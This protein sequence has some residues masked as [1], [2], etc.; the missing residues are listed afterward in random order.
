MKR[1][2]VGVLMVHGIQGGPKQFDF[3]KAALP[4]SY[5]VNCPTLPGHGKDIKE[6]R[7]S[8]NAQWLAAV[9]EAAEQMRPQC[10]R[11]FYV[12]HSMGCL[13]GILVSQQ[14]PS[15]FDGLLLRCCPYKTHPSAELFRQRLLLFQKH[16]SDQLIE[17][18]QQA[19]SVSAR[20][21]LDFLSC[22]HPYSQLTQLIALANRAPLPPVPVR[23]LFSEKDEIVSPSSAAIAAAKGATDIHMLSGCGHQ[24]FTQEARQTVIRQLFALIEEQ[25]NE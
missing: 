23:F 3:I 5:L 6:F 8:G 21:A 25:D 9:R 4:D 10:D 18:A 17:T 16:P 20:H 7:R 2:P 19:N 12:G 15:L 11:L 1:Y 14:Q 13:L 24:Y 22:V